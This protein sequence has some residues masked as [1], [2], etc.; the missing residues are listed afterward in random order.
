MANNNSFPVVGMIQSLL[1][2]INRNS[3]Q[4]HWIHMDPPKSDPVHSQ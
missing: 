2:K 4:V 3:K 1:S